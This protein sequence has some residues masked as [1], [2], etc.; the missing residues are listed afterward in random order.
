MGLTFN[1][2]K[3]KQQ[4][5]IAACRTPRDLNLNVLRYKCGIAKTF[6]IIGAKAVK[7]ANN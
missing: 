3:M 1:G 4:Y 2:K 5:I 6:T 7:Y